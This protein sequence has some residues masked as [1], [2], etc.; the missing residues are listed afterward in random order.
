MGAEPRTKNNLT[1]EE[2]KNGVCREGSV[3][4]S[5]IGTIIG[6]V[7]GFLA[8]VAIAYFFIRSKRK[9]LQKNSYFSPTTTSDINLN[10]S[11]TVME[12]PV[13]A[14][15]ITGINN[16]PISTF[17]KVEIVEEDIVALP[18]PTAPKN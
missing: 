11:V 3:I 5:L 13:Q 12:K 4:S 16:V 6:V 1:D 7:S 14:N 18:P 17:A 15:F 8:V 2:I 10:S 9:N